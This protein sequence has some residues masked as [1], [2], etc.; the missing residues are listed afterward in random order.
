MKQ[1]ANRLLR[2]CVYVLTISMLISSADAQPSTP[3]FPPI[4]VESFDLELSREFPGAEAVVLLDYGE[5]RFDFSSG[6]PKARYYFFRRIQFLEEPKADAGLIEITYNEDGQESLLNLRGAT[7]QLNSIGE[8]IA[9][10]LDR[11]RVEKEKDANDQRTISFELPFVKKGAII[12]Y[13]YSIYS[14]EINSL[15]PWRFQR[16]LPVLHS[17]YHTLLPEMSD[18][19]VIGRGNLEGLEKYREDG[20]GNTFLIHNIYMMNGV[21]A[22]RREAFMPV[23]RDIVPQLT[24]S[25]IE[26]RR[27][28][29][30]AANWEDFNQKVLNGKA[31]SLNRS[32]EKNLAAT[33]KNVTSGFRG[34]EEKAQA[35]YD[36]VQATYQW[37]GEYEA[38][39]SGNLN[40]VINQKK[41]SSAEINLIL[42]GML[43][44]AG[45]KSSPVLISTRENGRPQTATPMLAQF[46]HLIVVT[47]FNQENLLVDVVGEEARFLALPTMDLNGQ[48]FAVRKEKWGWMPIVSSDKLFRQTYS[49]IDLT[50]SGEISG[51][52]S[53]RNEGYTA[54][55]ERRRYEAYREP[56]AYFREQVLTGLPGAK[57]REQ[58]L[59]NKAE[60]EEPF[61]TLCE[62]ITKEKR[63]L[64]ST[65]DY[66]I[67]RPM[68]TRSI[69]ENPF[70]ET[71]RAYPLDLPMPTNERYVLAMV[72][73]EG[74]EAVQLPP[75]IH[76]KLPG[77]SGE[78]V[79]QS[80]VVGPFLQL[81][82]T[83]TLNQTVFMPNEYSAVRTFFDYI[84]G[85]HGEAIVFRRKSEQEGAGQD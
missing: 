9:F 2:A 75:P 57:I 48:G 64:E 35:I 7:Y 43:Q 62:F 71:E 29:L 40:R 60:S 15:K 78:F 24:F 59:R 1:I 67:F 5:V 30:T 27:E 74:Y 76:V 54:D 37:N 18:I 83:I 28:A 85:K 65:G 11:R 26:G 80:Q 32:A 81:V 82:S 66:L 55:R 68:L 31:L 52:I 50:A 34:K 73:P 47:E 49:R 20:G 72:I 3:K 39:S 44:A 22:I 14:D 51:I 21:S 33:V 77:E 41:G 23:E 36:Y 25:R 10:K 12:E 42:M 84:V 38:F 17:E 63:F 53:V 79:Y 58:T 19:V 16:I 45:L 6:V 4:E 13:G 46:N 8:P 70:R 69:P 56:E 61:V